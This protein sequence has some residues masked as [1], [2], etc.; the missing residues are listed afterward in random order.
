[1]PKWKGK[2]LLVCRRCKRK[3]K[4]ARTLAESL[5][6]GLPINGQLCGGYVCKTESERER[7]T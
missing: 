6:T 3:F 2:W 4:G 5:R 7:R 1:M